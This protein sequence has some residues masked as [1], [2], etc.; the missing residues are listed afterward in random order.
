M[1]FLL[2]ALL[3]TFMLIAGAMEAEAQTMP[4]EGHVVVM[5]QNSVWQPGPPMLPPGAETMV[6]YGNPTQ[7]GEF[8]MRLRLPAGYAVPPHTHPRLESVTII[9]GT[10]N[11]GMGDALQPERTRALDEGS[12]FAMPPGMTHYAFTDTGAVIQLNG[13]GPWDVIYV[14]PLDDPRRLAGLR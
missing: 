7:E 11:L 8:T 3:A 14:N 2:A 6:L 10:I 9:E 13:T 12:F 1:N 4:G 5:R